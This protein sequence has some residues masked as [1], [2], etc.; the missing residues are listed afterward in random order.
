LKRLGRM[1]GIYLISDGEV[2]KFGFGTLSYYGRRLSGLKH[3]AAET[4]RAPYMAL[5]T[6][7]RI[8]FVDF[9]QDL[10]FLPAPRRIRG[11]SH[12]NVGCGPR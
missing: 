4:G 12:G 7:E 2:G 1:Q 8:E 5:E 3:A 6:S 10:R 9:Y 11:R